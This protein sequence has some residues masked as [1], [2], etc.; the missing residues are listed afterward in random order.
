V[1]SGYDE[2]VQLLDSTTH[3]LAA[4]GGQVLRGAT[5]SLAAL[6]PADKPLHP[7][8]SV[9]RVS[10]VR[11]GGT[12]M[13][14]VAWLDEAGVDEVLVRLSRAI[15]LPPPAPDVF[16]IAL[17]VPTRPDRHGD[18]LFASTGLG[19]VTRFTL[20]AG[21]AAGS[22]PLTT[23][24]P[25]RSPTGPV[26]LSAVHEDPSAVVLSWARGTGPWHRFGRLDLGPHPEVADDEP[27][28]FDPLLNTVPGLENYGWVTRLR[29]PSYLTA[30]RSRR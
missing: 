5:R 29:E 9:L 20:T 7:E 11:S 2:A 28:S 23:L 16:G 19:R 22:R 24:L 3:G 6:R 30:R 17:R 13:S 8:G 25:Y 26:V 27:L 15:G 4:A 10:L 12:A 21:R 14:G 18:L 1:T